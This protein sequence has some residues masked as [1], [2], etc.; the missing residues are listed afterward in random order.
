MISVAGWFMDYTTKLGCV[1]GAINNSVTVNAVRTD[2]CVVCAG[3]LNDTYINTVNGSNLTMACLTTC[4]A[5]SYIST[6]GQATFCMPRCFP[7]MASTPR[8]TTI[9]Y[10]TTAN[11]QI[12]MSVQDAFSND[13]EPI[14][15]NKMFADP[16]SF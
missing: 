11:S 2:T 8:I 9:G 4:P 7:S 12:C 10:T 13:I 3:Y 15:G 5:T 1:W 16:L 6:Y 14:C